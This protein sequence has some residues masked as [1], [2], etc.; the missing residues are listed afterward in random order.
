MADSAPVAKLRS[1]VLAESSALSA[2]LP[3]PESAGSRTVDIELAQVVVDTCHIRREFARKSRQVSSLIKDPRRKQRGI[4]YSLIHLLYTPRA[5][6]NRVPKALKE[7]L[8]L[9][10]RQMRMRVWKGSI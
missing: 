9:T 2:N 8:F 4:S 6:G 3:E 5:A 7:F 1:V 10:V